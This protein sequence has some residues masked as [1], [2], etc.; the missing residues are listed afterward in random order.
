MATRP[1]PGSSSPY[2]TVVA[3]KNT[4]HGIPAIDLEVLELI[5]DSIRRNAV[6]HGAIL[7]AREKFD[8][9]MLVELAERDDL[10]ENVALAV[11]KL[12]GADD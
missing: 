10:S 5:G 2:V 3:V 1:L 9:A 6:H 8:E 12:L 4:K 7:S 11:A